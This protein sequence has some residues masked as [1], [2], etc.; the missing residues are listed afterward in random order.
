MY[1]ISHVIIID[2]T[3]FT[4]P[5]QKKVNIDNT[6]IRVGKIF[7]LQTLSI[8]TYHIFTLL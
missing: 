5:P 7:I 1:T 2:F 3:Y 8:P 4:Y 6:F